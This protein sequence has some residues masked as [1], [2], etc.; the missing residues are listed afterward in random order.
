MIKSASD[1]DARDWVVIDKVANK[2]VNLV[3]WANDESGEYHHL[4]LD[5]EGKLIMSD[6]DK[7]KPHVV[8]TKGNIQLM[9]ATDFNV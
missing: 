8:K 7:T 1:A 9:K 6:A 4:L 2:R 5:K 3:I